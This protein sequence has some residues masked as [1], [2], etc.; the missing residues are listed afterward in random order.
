MTII[1]ATLA[2]DLVDGKPVVRCDN[3]EDEDTI[4]DGFT[5]TGG[6]GDTGLFGAGTPVG[7]GMF[8]NGSSPT[9]TNCVFNGNIASSGGG[10]Y[11]NVGSPI[12]SGCTFSQNEAI[13]DGGA[14][15]NVT[16]N[17]TVT[18]CVFSD[19]L[20]GRRGGAMNNDA[21]S[22]IV[23]GCS[24]DANDV[25]G[26][27]AFNGGGGMYS[28]AGSSPTVTDCSFRF[29]TAVFW[30]G[31]MVNDGGTPM[32]ADC[33]FEGNEVTGANSWGGAMANSTSTATVT[34]ST[35]FGNISNVRG[36]A[37]ANLF[38]AF[39]TVI[40]C[41]FSGNIADEGGAIH[42]RDNSSPTIINSTFGGNMALLEGGGMFINDTSVPTINNS[43]FW[44]NQPDSLGGPG[45]PVVTFSDVEGGSIGNGN[46]D[47][48]PLFVDA[49]GA[50][51]VVGTD[52]DD[53][54]LSDGSPCIEAG[55][56]SLVTESIELDGNAR[57]VNCSVDM[58][59]Y[60]NQVG[61]PLV[62]N[63]TQN[64]FLVELQT[65]ID[66][67]VAGDVIEAAQCTFTEIIDFGGKAITLRS[68]DPT[69][70][71]V[72]AATIIDAT[73]VVDPG[74]GKPVVR[75]DSGEGPGTVLDGF[76][77]TGGTGDTAINPAFPS[78]GGMFVNSSSPTVTNCVFSG[79][80]AEFFGGGMYNASNS[81]PTVTNCTFSGNSAENFGGGMYN[82]MSNPTVTNCTFIANTATFR[83]GGM[84]NF[85]SSPT[86]TNCTLSENTANFGGGMCNN[87][88]AG[89]MTVMNCTFIGN[90]ARLDGG[91][92]YNESTSSPTVT[93][94]VFSA[95]TATLN[96]GGMFNFASS[97]VVTNC[98]LWGDS[99][100]EFAIEPLGTLFPVISFS[101]VQGG[102]PSEAIDG[103]GN[104]DADPLFVDPAGIDNTPGTVDDN[105]RLLA[106]S[107]CIDTGSNVAIPADLADLDGD[108]DTAEPTPLDLDLNPRVS[109]GDLDGA[110]AVDMGAYEL[111]SGAVGVVVNLT[112][113]TTHDTIAEAITSSTDGDQLLAS[114]GAVL[115]EPSINFLDR[116]I[117]LSSSGDI[118][119]SAG[120][121][122]R[123]AN[124][125]LL[126]TS[127][128][129]SITIGGEL[130]AN[131]SATADV[132]SGSLTIDPDGQLACRSGSF[133]EVTAPT[134]QLDGV[135]RIFDLATLSFT[136]ATTQN[137]DLTAFPSAT[138]TANTS[139]TNAGSMLLLNS[140][141][142]GDTVSTSGTMDVSGST[143]F[144]TGLT[145]D[146][147]G[148]LN[149]SGEIFADITNDQ[150]V[151]C[152]GDTLVVGE[153]TNNGT[154]IVQVGTLTI[155]GT[156]TNNGT[157]IGQVVGGAREV[158]GTS[159][160]DGLDISGDFIAGPAA[161][162][163][164]PDPVWRLRLL[165]DYDVAANDHQKYH[166]AQAELNLNGAGQ[167]LEVMS[168]DI[169]NCPA[170][171]NRS[172][173][174]HYPIGTLHIGPTSTIVDLVD[175]HENDPS[176]QG[177]PEAI[178]VQD[179]VIDSGATLNT[180]LNR[181]YY[182][183]LTLA[184]NVD[185]L[186]N[187]ILIEPVPGDFSG[188]CVTSLVDYAPFFDCMGGPDLPPIP[189]A[190]TTP[191]QCLDAFDF[192]ND[193]DIDAR[194]FGRF[195]EV[196]G[197]TSQG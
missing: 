17:P 80:T 136:G 90:T 196:F 185:D 197:S 169:G 184:G 107:P 177:Q 175:A 78:G 71:A 191:Q 91:G 19:N 117:T 133:M 190:P 88:G 72:V 11:N 192:D 52:D 56:S 40:G 173:A 39:P 174:G 50:D 81:N 165:G 161:S 168:L 144:G 68:T 176:G 115:S 154:T 162:L 49:D 46:I 70:P 45:I 166:M 23:T 58:G 31:G 18:S 48:D 125:S 188:D 102:L 187:L 44:G 179:L 141:M 167:T 128:G 13:L 51:D 53:L 16:S 103:G 33:V 26:L 153:Y 170:G 108:L 114:V 93:N 7:G 134:A 195:S 10:M 32:I 143:I 37:M 63:I 57:I 5:I 83:G 76:T 132:V 75:C 142:F 180:N 29:N 55:D 97:P 186:S 150:D 15:A 155:V 129:K 101:D 157:I 118:N 116:A 147:G 27:D 38:D 69:N 14:M 64:L 6:T 42:N 183:S 73:N 112:Q 1:D 158:G 85:Q 4:L 131:A 109:D 105:L 127:L 99:P 89:T 106:P 164:M 140:T 120:G 181:V 137:G 135:T 3:G 96:G 41:I 151:F 65:A 43:V 172:L 25:D 79:N 156:L 21:S 9:V 146:T 54:R 74:T 159:P 24:F 100:E 126:D 182:E 36:G 163:S 194:D 193:N 66:S 119:Q 2:A 47:A 20:A 123:L 59:A 12:V 86:V 124:G 92:M 8:V 148:R 95:N 121:I 113:S 35:F 189:S 111:D 94:S 178:Y 104:I 62:H 67:A 61:A 84:F 171:L 122:Y 30:G 149:L 77:I 22:P 110:A 98:I 139:F 152:L 34:R 82:D 87:G 145:V 138:L 130:R 60:E 28:R 160:G